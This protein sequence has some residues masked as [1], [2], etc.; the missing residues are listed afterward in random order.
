[1]PDDGETNQCLTP[2]TVRSR[3]NATRTAA[4]SSRSRI[5][6]GARRTARPGTGAVRGR[7]RLC[8]FIAATIR[9]GGD[10]PQPSHATKRRPL[11]VPPLPIAPMPQKYHRNM[12]FNVDNQVYGQPISIRAIC[13]T[14]ARRAV[15]PYD[16]PKTLT[17]RRARN[18]GRW[19]DA[20]NLAGGGPGRPEGGAATRG[21]FRGA[22]A[23][24]LST[25]QPCPGRTGPIGKGAV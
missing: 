1:M 25:G 3:S 19:R 23:E 16:R 2:A 14:G 20:G 22:A 7:D 9:E 24:P 13:A 21:A 8:E 17:G 15:V 5:S 10:L 12:N 4:M 18:T 6:A 11:V